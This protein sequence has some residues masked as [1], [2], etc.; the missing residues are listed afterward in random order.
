M[1]VLENPPFQRNEKLKNYRMAENGVPNPQGY[2]L[3]NGR[4]IKEKN[5]KNE[6]ETEKECS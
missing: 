5:L 1:H 4:R 3:L 2:W 6:I